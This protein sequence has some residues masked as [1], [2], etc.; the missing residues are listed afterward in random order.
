MGI[1]MRGIDMPFTRHG[2]RPDIIMNPNAIPSRMTIGQLWECLLGKVGALKG[3]NMD[4]TAFEDYDI[5]AV[6]DMLEKIGYQRDCE[7]YLY[8]GMTGKMIKHMIFIGPVYYQ[9]LKHMV[10]DKMH[11]CDQK[12]EVLT[13]SGWKLIS[14]ITKK[15]KVATLVDGKIAYAN[16]TDIHA[17]DNYEG[18]MYYVKNDT[19]DLAV[20]GNH[21]MLVSTKNE[22]G[23]WCEYQLQYAE[24]IKGQPKRYVHEAEW[25]VPD[26]NNCSEDEYL[27]LV[28][29]ALEENGEICYD[30]VLTKFSRNQAL[31]LLNDIT[32]NSDVYVTSHKKLAD[33]IQHLCLHAGW[34]CII[35]Q[36]HEKY[37]CRID[38]EKTYTIVNEKYVEDK[39]VHENLPVYCLTVPGEVFYVRRNGKAVWT[40]NSR[41][42]GPVTILTRQ[43]PE[44]M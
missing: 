10:Q 8:N 9:R 21:R 38:R 27:D 15:D 33:Q 37:V 30:W 20:T 13:I 44:G 25:D 28:D 32:K 11:C 1:G 31:K 14:E 36:Q 16:P 24:Q 29:Q 6:K 42:S 5:E 35:N 34:M 4:G 23:Q 2:I 22:E 19:I 7:E 43:A 39:I 12:T 40:G 3:M 26:Y 41:A 17:S 18:T